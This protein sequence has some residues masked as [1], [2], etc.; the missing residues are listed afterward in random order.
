MQFKKLISA[1]LTVVFIFMTVGSASVFSAY[2]S[3]TES[4]K[5]EFEDNIGLLKTLGILDSTVQ[6]DITRTVTRAEMTAAVMKL[7][8]IPN[9]EYSEGA[10]PFSDVNGETPECGYIIAAAQSGIVSGSDG[11]FYPNDKVLYEEAAKIMVGFLGYKFLAEKNGGYPNGYLSQA[12]RL[13]LLS[14]TVGYS[15]YVMSWF[16]MAR[17]LT[18]ALETDIMEASIG[19]NGEV[20]YTIDR[21][22]NILGDVL[23]IKTVKGIVTRSMYTGLT[24]PRNITDGIIEID[25]TEYDTSCDT[26]DLIGCRVKAYVNRDD[27]II[28]IENREKYNNILMFD[29]EN[30]KYSNFTYEYQDEN[31][32]K[33]DKYDI[34]H[35]FNLIYNNK[36]KINFT[37]SDMVPENGFV[38]LTDA[39]RDGDFETVKV[40]DYRYMMVQRTDS[41][42]EV[43]YGKYGGSK[44]DIHG[45]K[46]LDIRDQNGRTKK[47]TELAEYDVVRIL[48][49]DD[50]EIL[51][52]DV[53]KER[54]KGTI[55]EFNKSDSVTEVT[56]GDKEFKT[57]KSPIGDD[58]DTGRSG[59]LY[60]ASDGKA[61]A[62]ISGNPEGTVLGI[63][64][65]ALKEE[66]MDDFAR[67]KVYTETGELEVLECADKVTVDGAGRSTADEIISVLKQGEA[68]VQVQPI[69]Y[70]VNAS[71]KIKKIDTAYN[72][73]KKYTGI[74]PSDVKPDGSESAESLRRVYKGSQIYMATQATFDGKL[75]LSDSTKVFSIP[76]D[77]ATADKK[78]FS[79]G[80]KGSLSNDT[81]YEF[82][83][84]STT[85][86]NLIADIV[87][88]YSGISTD[89]KYAVVTGIKGVYD[90]DSGETRTAVALTAWNGSEVLYTDDTGMITNARSVNT[91]DTNTYNISV[92]DFVAYAK[93]GADEINTIELV[94]DASD[95]EN[96]YKGTKNPTSDSF[97]AH[98]R[99]LYGRVETNYNGI[100]SINKGAEN[101]NCAATLFR[102]YKCLDGRNGPEIKSISARDIY[103]F[104]VY[105]DAANYVVMCSDWA[106]GRIIV[107]Y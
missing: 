15:G 3:F 6:Y 82:D 50:N 9:V 43:I 102:V 61:A 72:I 75:N 64:V 104:N 59:V 19:K 52:I 69:L 35:K 62:F 97:S 80:G 21:E 88:T 29:A 93:S 28:Y 89:R 51:F 18:A 73:H 76:Q 24:E 86:T 60:I 107:V 2:D 71:G 26:R 74:S 4:E 7:F 49:S 67:L 8:G 68:D 30:L 39:D 23:H 90:S 42:N 12:A 101:E 11:M 57:I 70:T 94:A 41:E 85:E 65:N 100:I 91:A 10:S 87:I 96:R 98:N 83:A 33:P 45:V 103:D 34:P 99:V 63:L 32:R 79:I 77:P 95:K 58:I 53:S 5:T 55:N 36:A 47:Y 20:R 37:E 54:L 78:N 48:A 105:G 40:Y 106:E 92:G 31:K 1:A 22:R 27:E 16:G 56:L 14:P 13:G 44:V 81:T 84:Y 66:R 25:K 38:I 17:M 46:I